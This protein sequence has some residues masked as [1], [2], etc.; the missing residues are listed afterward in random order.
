MITIIPQP[1][2]IGVLWRL[3][4]KVLDV[5]MFTSPGHGVLLTQTFYFLRYFIPVPVVLLNIIR[6]F[7]HNL[8]GFPIVWRIS[9]G[10]VTEVSQHGSD[11]RHVFNDIVRDV[12]NPLGQ[13]LKIDWFDDLV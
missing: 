7:N 2:I 5:V 13:R 8:I 10:I 11:V 4:I 1:A 3:L 12:T 6:I 9:R